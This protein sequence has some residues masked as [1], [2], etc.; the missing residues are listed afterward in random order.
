LSWNFETTN[1]FRRN[2]KKL[3]SSSETKERINHALGVLSN[4]EEPRTLGEAKYGKWKGAYSYEIGRQYRI[5]YAVDFE[6]RSIILLSVGSHKI[7]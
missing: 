5:L 3:S 1:A 2:Y 4:T 7:Y 6:K